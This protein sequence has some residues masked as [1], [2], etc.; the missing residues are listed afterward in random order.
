MNGSKAGM[1]G[2]W[3]VGRPNEKPSTTA[4]PLLASKFSEY[5]NERGRGKVRRRGCWNL[6]QARPYQICVA[7]CCKVISHDIVGII[8]RLIQD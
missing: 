1:M 2:W 5:C 6:S 4:A 8:L 3:K 7:L